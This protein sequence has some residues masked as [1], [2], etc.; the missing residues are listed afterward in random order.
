MKDSQPYDKKP[1]GQILIEAG[2]ISISQIELALQ[3]QKEKNLRI[4]EILVSHNWI[5]LETIDFFCDRWSDLIQEKQKRPIAYYFLE[6]GL[7]TRDQCEAIIRLQKLK[8]KKVRFHRLA[9]EQGYLKQTTVDFFL[10][11]LFKVH[12]PNAISIAK[13][14]ELLRDYCKGNKDF[15]K[16]DLA[17]APLMGVSLKGISL[18]GSN[19]RKA[20][21][22]KANLSNSSLVQVNLSLANLSNA[23]LNE[24]NFTRAFL[25]RANL[26][27]AHLEGANFQNAI[28]H[29]VNFQSAYL[30]Q[31]NFA[32]ADL[33]RAKLPLDYSYA[34][35]YD[36]YTIYDDD[37]DPQIMEWKKSTNSQPT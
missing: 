8:Q 10:A 11:Y 22:S 36:Q 16:I 7:L 28:L 15:P 32:G 9:T 19:L 26:R 31:A 24:A 35:Y 1:L 30:A 2:L 5:S 20:D 33:T 13:P 37:F 21:F 23:V 12:D 14:Y 18:N 17:K 34:V 27:E 29:E 25:T 3:E 4:G 6:A